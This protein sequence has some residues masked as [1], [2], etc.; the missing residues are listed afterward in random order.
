MRKKRQGGMLSDE[1][2]QDWKAGMLSDITSEYPRLAKHDWRL[3]EGDPSRNVGG[4][5]LEFYSPKQKGNPSPGHPTIEVYP[6]TTKLPREEVKKMVYGD[7][8][9]YLPEVDPEWNSLRSQYAESLTDDQRKTDRMAYQRELA[10]NLRLGEPWSLPVREGGQ[11][12][13]YSEFM[14][15]S[16]LDA[17][18]RGYLAPDR[19]NE[20]AGM[21]KPHQID[22]LKRM[23][24][25]LGNQ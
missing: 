23:R 11:M 25:L 2:D 9:H 13:P 21:Y 5:Y 7:M 24:G 8:L 4:G 16:R 14:D 22:I 19:R 18:I 17:H 10:R 3:M 20:W 12:R 6:S 1:E 15:M